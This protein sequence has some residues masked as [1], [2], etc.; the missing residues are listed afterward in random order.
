MLAALVCVNLLLLAS[1]FSTQQVN[2]VNSVIC[3]EPS[4]CELLS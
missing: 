1:S 4:R 3:Q 2:P